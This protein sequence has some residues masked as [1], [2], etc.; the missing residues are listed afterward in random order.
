[1]TGIYRMVW[2]AAAIL[3]C[4]PP[5]ASAQAPPK[6]VSRPAL[7]YVCSNVTGVIITAPRWQSESDG[8]SGQEVRLVFGGDLA[9]S[10]VSWRKG[11]STYYETDGVG[12][13]LGSGFAILI[14]AED[15]I[16]TYVYSAGTTELLF[17]STRLGSKVLPNAMKAFRGTCT[18]GGEKGKD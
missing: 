9:P 16:E 15:R 5:S 1:M 12:F 6:A 8:A 10:S 4:S 2:A 7:A 11:E 14:H 3:L 13:S 17:S 18:P